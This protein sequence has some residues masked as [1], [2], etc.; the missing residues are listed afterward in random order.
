MLMV[1]RDGPE[2]QTSQTVNISHPSFGFASTRRLRNADTVG[3]QS[4]SQVN[5]STIACFAPLTKTQVREA[6]KTNT[7]PS[8]VRQLDVSQIAFTLSDQT[9][10]TSEDGTSFDYS[11]RVRDDSPRV[12]DDLSMHANRPPL[13]QFRFSSE[14]KE[15]AANSETSRNQQ[16]SFKKRMF[17]TK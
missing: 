9:T 1:S 4:K 7:P 10:P 2:T 14:S 15:Q 3:T 12:R 11:P 17:L 16:N 8:L 6:W 5:T 13:L